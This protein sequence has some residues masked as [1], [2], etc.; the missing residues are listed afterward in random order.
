[1]PSPPS[2]RWP[3]SLWLV[4]HGES[5]GNVA[6]DAAEA[7]GLP[8]IDVAHRDMDVPLSALGEE[9]ATVLGRWLATLPE[10]ERPTHTIASPYVRAQ[11]TARRILEASGCPPDQIDIEV[12]E[13]LREREF[14]IL[15]RLTK[16]GIEE[17]HP[18]QAAARAFLGKFYH[19]PPGGESWADVGLRLRSVLDSIGR[20]YAGERLLV[21][22]H[23]V[24]ITV[25]RYLLE[26]LSEEQVLAI[27]RAEELANCSVTAFEL[28]PT[29]GR[30]GG[31]KLVR[32]NDVSPLRAVGEPVTREPDARVDPR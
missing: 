11:T 4:R 14:G 3:A 32:W 31:M 23:Q 16:A 8:M 19:R 26:R 27:D 5:A 6:R 18:E 9:Q 22:T 10:D 28:D 1:V 2:D 30:H 12:D 21:V 29:I 20:Q 13:R 15:D 7:A 17:R 24:V 25:F